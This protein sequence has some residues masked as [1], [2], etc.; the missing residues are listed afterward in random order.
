MV[1][2]RV[3]VYTDLG[4]ECDELPSRLFELFTKMRDA[5]GVEIYMEVIDRGLLLGF[6]N[7][8]AVISI[9]G[10]DITFEC[11]KLSESLLE[12]LE[13]EVL[14]VVASLSRQFSS[15]EEPTT[16]IRARQPPLD[17]TIEIE[18]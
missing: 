2:I 4:T 11:S 16:L 6:S 1:T 8:L 5:Y 15:S 18:S 10:Y 13:E 17:A 7:S 9:K 3:T 14:R 12:S